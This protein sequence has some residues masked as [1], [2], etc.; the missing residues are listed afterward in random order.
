MSSPVTLHVF[1]SQKIPASKLRG[2]DQAEAFPVLTAAQIARVREAGRVRKVEVD[3]ILYEP[4]AAHAP[5]F[6]VLSGSL[7]IAQPDGFGGDRALVTYHA[8]SFTGEMTTISNRSGIARGRVSES[9]EFIELNSEQLLALIA[10]DAE[11]NEILMRLLFSGA[12][13]C[14]RP[15]TEMSF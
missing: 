3:E 12:R 15:A 9:G 11:L 5:F 10:R 4:G 1:E 6:V 13:C 7:H 8:G 2:F 14:F